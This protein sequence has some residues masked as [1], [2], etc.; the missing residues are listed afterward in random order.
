MWFRKLHKI[1]LYAVVFEKF[2]KLI[3]FQLEKSA[4]LS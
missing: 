2:E 1:Q 4:K 3:N